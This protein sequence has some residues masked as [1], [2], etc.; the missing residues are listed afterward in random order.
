MINSKKSTHYSLMIMLIITK[1]LVE[2]LLLIEIMKIK[3]EE[4]LKYEN[5]C[6][7]TQYYDYKLF[8]K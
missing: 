6:T 3:N 5:F 7:E 1:D 8:I 4:V 2:E